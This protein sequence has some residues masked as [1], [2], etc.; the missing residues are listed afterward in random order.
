MNSEH[1]LG[2][3]SNGSKVASWNGVNQ[4]D[5]ALQPTFVTEGGYKNRPYVEFFR[6]S[7]SY[8]EV[9]SLNI[10]L[11]TNRG[12]TAMVLVRMTEDVPANNG[13]RIY[14][15]GSIG[16]N[17]NFLGRDNN[18]YGAMEAYLFSQADNYEY[19]LFSNTTIAPKNEWA[20]WAVSTK[21]SAFP[22]TL[23]F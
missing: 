2:R 1:L 7:L 16:I 18:N 14:D 22:N 23:A 21:A 17:G 11:L 6:N 15:F 4:T 12:F 3:L 13:E 8:F 19:Q 20:L 10:K 5:P 9:G